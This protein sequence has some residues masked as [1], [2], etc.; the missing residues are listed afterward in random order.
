MIEAATRAADRQAFAIRLRADGALVGSSS[1]LD[2]RP[3]HRGVEIGYTWI[4]KRWQRTFVN[5]EAK[6]LLL[7]HAFVDLDMVRVQLKTD[8]RNHQSQAAMEKLGCVR[9]GVLRKHMILP[10]GHIRDTVLYSITA[11]EWPA[12]EARLQTRLREV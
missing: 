5:P 4:A 7:R 3:V 12:V 2:F 10:D 1:L 8:A 6:L 11:D 9:E